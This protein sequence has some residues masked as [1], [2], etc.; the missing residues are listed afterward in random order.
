MTEAMDRGI[1]RFLEALEESGLAKNTLIIFTS[2]NGSYNGSNQPLRGFKGMIFEGGIRVPW[3]F[4]W[5]GVIEPG[6]INAT[7]I[8]SM[9]SF[10]TILEAAGIE[11]EKDAVIDGVSLMPLLKQS[12]DF[13]REA[14]FFHYPNYAFH[15]REPAGERRPVGELQVD[16]PLR[17]QL[18]R[19]L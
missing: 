4:R 7:P 14:I 15:K 12:G 8:I 11:L 13:K 10:P 6:S 9:D 2:D 5:P 19:T 16:P 18:A 17:R 3:I 1:G